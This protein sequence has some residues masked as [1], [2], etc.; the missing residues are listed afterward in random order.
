MIKLI[1]T[2]ETSKYCL[3]VDDNS[4]FSSPIH[5]MPSAQDPFYV[6]KSEI[7]ESVSVFFFIFS[8]NLGFI[9]CLIRLRN[10]WGFS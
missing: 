10:G 5:N 8:N 1:K 9:F 4:F 7:Q 3:S 2:R 6:V